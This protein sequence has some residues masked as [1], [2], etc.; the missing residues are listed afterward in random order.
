MLYS[1]NNQ[2]NL[3]LDGNEKFILLLRKVISIFFGRPNDEMD[4]FGRPQLVVH[5]RPLDVQ[6]HP[7]INFSKNLFFLIDFLNKKI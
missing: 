6:N 5:Y 4:D 3:H 7:L 1:S 2:Y